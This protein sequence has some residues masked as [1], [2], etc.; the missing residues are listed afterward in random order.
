MS[1]ITQEQWLEGVREVI[2]NNGLEEIDKTRYEA[3][4]FI[5]EARIHDSVLADKVKLLVD[6]A[7]QSAI[8]IRNYLKEKVG[9]DGK[10]ENNR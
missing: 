2:S 1:R 10:E 4:I 8:D 5:E 6:N 9:L 3:Y 7:L